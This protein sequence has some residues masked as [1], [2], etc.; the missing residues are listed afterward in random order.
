MTSNQKRGPQ[1][2]SMFEQAVVH[3][4]QT[5]SI[6]SVLELLE[7]NGHTFRLSKEVGA[8]RAATCAPRW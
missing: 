4:H 8:H 5:D 3:L 7:N 1:G 6:L 2:A